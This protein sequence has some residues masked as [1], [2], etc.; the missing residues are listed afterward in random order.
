MRTDLDSDRITNWGKMF[1]LL[2]PSLAPVLI[3]FRRFLIEGIAITAWKNQARDL[4][5]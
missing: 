5:I 1:A 2:S 4:L 3:I